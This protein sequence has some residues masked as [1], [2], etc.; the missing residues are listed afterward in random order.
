MSCISLGCRTHS[1]GLRRRPRLGRT[2]ELFHRGDG[3][4]SHASGCYP[5]A[6]PDEESTK[7]EAC[8]G[9]SRMRKNKAS[10]R[11]GAA[12]E[13]TKKMYPGSQEK[14]VWL[15]ERKD[16]VYWVLIIHTTWTGVEH[17]VSNMETLGEWS[18]SDICGVVGWGIKTMGWT[19]EGIGEKVW[20]RVNVNHSRNI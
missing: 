1:Q 12:R 17:S 3:T 15:R 14:K 20:D 9:V 4:W 7:S 5:L 19:Q 6:S 16:P 10:H 18:G 13:G 11:E 8:L 2:F